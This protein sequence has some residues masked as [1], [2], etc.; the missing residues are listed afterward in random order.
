MRMNIPASKIITDN[1]FFSNP[2]G[3]LEFSLNPKYVPGS[4]PTT[5]IKAKM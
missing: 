3:T 2:I 5:K 4:E 1:I